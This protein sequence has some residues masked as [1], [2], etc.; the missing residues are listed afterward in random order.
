MWKILIKNI[1]YLL[2]K[3]KRS[4]NQELVAFLLKVQLFSINFIRN[5]NKKV[6][7]FV[8]LF[9]LIL[10]KLKKNL[11]LQLLSVYV[12]FLIINKNYIG[13]LLI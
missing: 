4:E 3:H 10:H 9:L 5:Q 12:N 7:Y 13:K 11:I 6:G 1:L 8:Y 2:D